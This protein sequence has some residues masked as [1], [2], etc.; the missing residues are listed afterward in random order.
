MAIVAVDQ[1][2]ELGMV[3]DVR[4]D[5][6]PPHAFTNAHNVRFVDGKVRNRKGEIQVYGTPTIVP[7]LAMQF[8]RP[9]ENPG[10]VYPGLTKI[11]A[12]L[13]GTE[14]N[15][16]RQ[17][18]AV[19]VDYNAIAS[20]R[21]NGG[22]QSGVMILN[23]GV[24]VPQSWVGLDVGVKFTDLPNWPS[25]W[26][27]AVVR[28]FKSYLLALDVTESSVRYPTRLRW[29]HAA[30][31][32]TVPSSWDSTD[33]TLDAGET[34]VGGS[35]GFL[36]DAVPLRDS[37]VLY[38]QDSVYLLTY[39]GGTFVFQVRGLF[40]NFGLANR[41]CAVEYIPGQ[42]FVF[43]GTD[44]YVHNGQTAESILKGRARD[45][46]ARIKTA[47]I[48]NCFVTVHSAQDEVWFCYPTDEGDGYG[49]LVQEA[50]VWNWKSGALSYRDLRNINYITAGLV[51]T[52]TS[53]V[54]E[55]WSTASGTWVD[56]ALPWDADVTYYGGVNLLGCTTTKLVMFEQGY[57]SDSA[58]LPAV[59]ERT[60][61]AF[62]VAQNKPPDITR[63]KFCKA[64]W[65]RLA[66][67]DMATVYVTVGGQKDVNAPV[68]WEPE[69]AYVIGQTKKINC[70]VSA[71]TLAL[72][73]R[74]EAAFEWELHGV[75]FDI[76]PRG[77]F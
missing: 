67:E 68:V 2:A 41:D 61:Y 21:W 9:G 39:V 36:V 55:T 8:R 10:W 24:D 12:T 71:R 11:Y 27:A 13:S 5:T 3:V 43:T 73:F 15:L 17:T 77:V 40:T 20:L 49:G 48:T 46:L 70:R 1:L 74:S 50:L 4:P 69:Q 42:H 65:L 60:G 64:V 62:P 19:D 32:G 76:V 35:L 29:S 26:R 75:E 28:P 34:P 52:Q 54:A 56:D 16:T 31:P 7:Y 66:G 57:L 58:A 30:D 63:M 47:N 38:K 72:R 6:L 44:I 25:A 14:Y 45:W 18:A 53:V 33:V 37:M 22:V 23:S 51:D 59:L